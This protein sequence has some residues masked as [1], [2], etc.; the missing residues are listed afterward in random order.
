MVQMTTAQCAMC[1][2]AT[3]HWYHLWLDWFTKCYWK[4]YLLGKSR[5]LGM[6]NW[7]VISLLF[8]QLV[9]MEKPGKRKESL[10]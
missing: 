9:E 3:E 2:V 8:F 10:V 4:Q 6:K 1:F 5:Q 7:K